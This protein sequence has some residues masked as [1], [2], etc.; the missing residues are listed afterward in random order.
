MRKPASRE[1]LIAYIRKLESRVRFL[2]T[3]AKEHQNGDRASTTSSSRSEIPAP[4][5]PGSPDAEAEPARAAAKTQPIQKIS[6]PPEPKTP[7]FMPE[8]VKKARL[9]GPESVSKTEA[10]EPPTEAVSQ[11]A[12]DLGV[13]P[14][15]PPP[16][17]EIRTKEPPP[18]A[19]GASGALYPHPHNDPVVLPIPDILPPAFVPGEFAKQVLDG[20][21]EQVVEPLMGGLSE[22]RECKPED[23]RSILLRMT[24]VYW[25]AVSR[26]G[27]RIGREE[28][29]WPKRLFLRFGILDP[30][31]LNDRLWRTLYNENSPIGETGVYYLDEWLEAIYSKEIKYSSIDEMA[32]KGGK[33]KKDASGEEC[34]G[35]ELMNISQMQ[36]MVVGPR[37]NLIAILTSDYC[38]PSRDNPLLLREWVYKTYKMIL[39]FDHTMFRR[40][41]KG[42]DIEAEPLWLV[43]PGYGV[44]SA[45]WEPWSP[46]NKRTGPRSL[47]CL[48]PPRY[49]LKAL[50]DALSDYR[51]T[52]AKEDAMHY[53]LSEGLT[54]KFLAMFSAKE[55]RRDMKA[56]FRSFYMHWMLNEARRVPKLDKRMRDFFYYNCPY[57][58]EVKATL[59]AG[60]VFAHT[61]EA[62]MAKR[63]RDEKERE[64]LERMKAM[65]EARK[66]M[67][68]AKMETT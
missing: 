20:E 65:R 3:Q 62:E 17:H 22:L 32:L 39:P 51:W 38:T 31:L 48:F 25:T 28:L 42:E 63:E 12:V 64:E 21:E 55:Q 56:L 13:G 5:A 43:L 44:R 35:Y 50:I 41:Y 59:R 57:S 33:A 61:I 67:R 40:K 7:L 37:A 16:A 8:K 58:D 46:G 19:P 52:Y 18:S 47:V 14:P 9:S 66:A 30:E 29:S 6:T 36:R 11:A 54:G 49:S 45:C 26:M 2:E 1:R 68:K 60:G 23:R 53:W 27:A 24:S 10:S 34:V 4:R 15:P